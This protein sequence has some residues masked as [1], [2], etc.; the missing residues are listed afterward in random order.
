MKKSMLNLA[1][2][3]LLVSLTLNGQNAEKTL[4]RAF[5]LQGNHNV[6]I[7]INGPLEVQTWNQDQMRVMMTISIPN[8]S[9]MMLKN[10]VKVG[11]YNLTSAED[12]N[13]LK[14][15]APGLE[16]Q[17]KLRNGTELE[18]NITMVVYAPHNVQVSGLNETLLLGQ[19]EEN[20]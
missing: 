14:V 3:L 16:K 12:T 15:F 18:E 19:A 20:E 4:V 7:D 5:N 6:L 2:P 10:L 8:A 11:R 1:V 13:G 9:D 17:V